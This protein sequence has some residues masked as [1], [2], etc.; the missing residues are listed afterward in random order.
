MRNLST[1]TILFNV[2]GIAIVVT[3]IGYMAHNLITTERVP[4]CTSRFPAGQQFAFDGETGKPRSPIELQGRSGMREWGVLKN[5]HI[6]ATRGDPSATTLVVSLATTGNEENTDQ[7]GVGFV[8]PISD[9]A[10]AHSSCLSYNVFFPSGFKFTEPGYLPGV[11]GAADAAQLDDSKPADSFAVRM[12]W[13]QQGAIGAEI[14]APSTSGYWQ[15]ATEQAL[16]PLGRWV[17][18]EQEV[19]LNTPGAD[20]GVVRIWIDGS[21]TVES[22]VTNLRVAPQST[23]TGVVSEIGYARTASDVASIKVSPFTMQWQ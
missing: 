6:V 21:L 7:N 2:A 18:V 9:L 22:N 3:A 13:A 5:A 23:L 17:S 15:G 1:N 20:D 11:F 14:R 4:R 12:G 10:T 16:W 8:W 19:S